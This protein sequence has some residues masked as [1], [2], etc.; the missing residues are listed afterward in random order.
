MLNTALLSIIFARRIG[1]SKNEVLDL[2]MRIYQNLAWV[3]YGG[4]IGA[5]DFMVSEIENSNE[6]QNRLAKFGIGCLLLMIGGF[7]SGSSI[8]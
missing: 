6:N 4:S 1:L 5:G 7:N 8:A 2:G 3:I